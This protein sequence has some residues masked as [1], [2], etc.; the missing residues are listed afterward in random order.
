MHLQGVYY[1]QKFYCVYTHVAGFVNPTSA[2]C[3]VA[4]RYGGLV[5]CGPTSKV[6]WDRSTYVFWDPYHPTDAANV[7]VAENLL[8]GGSN[9][10]W[11]RNIRGLLQT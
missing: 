2:C 4:G 5:P 7:I 6:C 11:P 8:E 9:Y 1:E 10:I 3:R